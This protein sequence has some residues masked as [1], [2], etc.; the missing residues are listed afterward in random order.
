MPSGAKAV[1]WFT[2]LII[3][4]QDTA[5]ND[6]QNLTEWRDESKNIMTS[7]GSRGNI[8]MAT[9]QFGRVEWTISGTGQWQL[10]DPN[11]G[12]FRFAIYP[13]YTELPGLRVKEGTNRQMGTA[14][15]AAGTVTV[16]TT[17]VTANSRI[18]LTAQNT[19]GTPGALRVS[20]RTA[21][22]SF[23]ITSTSNTDTSLVAWL[24]IEPTSTV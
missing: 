10:W 4:R 1:K 7:V 21:G 22:T 18:Q 12:V 13:T 24:L 19:G 17:A 9:D 6:T 11:S 23:T 16:S 8:T 5:A 20:A 15:L 3:Q 2:N 14:T